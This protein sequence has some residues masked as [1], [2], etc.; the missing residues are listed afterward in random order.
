M[1]EF[2]LLCN[3][4]DF[5]LS[6]KDIIIDEILKYH[7]IEEQERIKERFNQTLILFYDEDKEK[8][9]YLDNLIDNKN[10]ELLKKLFD[11]FNIKY[12][13]E[14]FKKKLSDLYMSSIEVSFHFD[15]IFDSKNKLGNRFIEEIVKKLY[16]ELGFKIEDDEDLLNKIRTD[17]KLYSYFKEINDY[18]IT[19]ADEFNNYKNYIHT[20]YNKFYRN[21][22]S[23]A[24]REEET[25]INLYR[26]FIK[27]LLD[28]GLVSDNDKEILKT[29]SVENI[30]NYFD[31]RLLDLYKEEIY[32]D[33]SFK[34]GGIDFI[35]AN[36]Y[37]QNLEK[38]KS[39]LNNCNIDDINLSEK[40]DMILD[41]RETLRDEYL[42]DTIGE[43]P[44]I[45]DVFK[46]IK[47]Y[48][49][50][51]GENPNEKVYLLNNLILCDNW[52]LYK[53]VKCKNISF[54]YERRNHD[55]FKFLK[56]SPLNSLNL[57]ENYIQVLIHEMIH[58]SDNNFDLG[59]LNEV[60]VEKLAWKVYNSIINK[61]L[62]KYPYLKL[63]TLNRLS[64][65]DELFPLVDDFV[66][67]NFDIL[68]KGKESGSMEYFYE[69][70]GKDN[71]DEFMKYINEKFDLMCQYNLPN[72]QLLEQKGNIDEIKDNMRDYLVN[73]HKHK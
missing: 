50:F 41:F 9:T 22:E 11:K 54:W 32:S 36:K 12:N 16:L 27:F 71:F 55:I 26:E 18:R 73:N 70:F 23:L 7:D 64:A 2:D 72:K 1:D 49:N 15:A 69:K 61:V 58:I 28:N 20:R 6:I 46:K 24:K 25:S 48:D 29:K 3:F 45:K 17:K 52:K 13:D 67:E 8:V 10:K 42:L 37:D 34:V 62:V 66:E 30:E 4:D 33:A 39:Y 59:I 68:L 21:Q 65:Y 47:L 56:C 57:S 40:I 35:K 60:L 5:Y 63:D 51:F 14:N 53:D 38:T 44:E 31:L 43:L 19:L